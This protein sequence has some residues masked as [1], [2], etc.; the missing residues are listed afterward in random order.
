M[1]PGGAAQACH[2]SKAAL[3]FLEQGLVHRRIGNRLHRLFLLHWEVPVPGGDWVGKGQGLQPQACSVWPRAPPHSAPQKVAHR[4]TG[5]V[6]C[7]G[8]RGV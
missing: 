4:D 1:G 5:V 8:T 6:S 2:T 7:L 3:K